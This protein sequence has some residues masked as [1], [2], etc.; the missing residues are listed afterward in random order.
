MKKTASDLGL[1]PKTYDALIAVRDKL[2]DGRFRHISEEEWDT[3]RKDRTFDGVF[4][5]GMDLK[6]Y[7]CGT[8]GCIGGW[9]GIELGIPTDYQ[10]AYDNDTQVRSHLPDLMNDRHNPFS[11]E[12]Y[13]TRD[14]PLHLLFFPEVEVNWDRL[15]PRDAVQAINN[16]LHTGDA[17]H[18]WNFTN[19]KYPIEDSYDD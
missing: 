11:S 15:T 5:M 13:T 18:S 14:N 17:R 10:K 6:D 3:I 19:D 7:K 16:Y 2:A 4:N 9:M 12:F 1:Q 8:V